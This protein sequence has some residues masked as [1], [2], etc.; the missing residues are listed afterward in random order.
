MPNLVTVHESRVGPEETKGGKNGG[1]K[2][3]FTF[4]EETTFFRFFGRNW[5]KLKF[6]LS[7]C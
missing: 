7:F 2:T 1:K 3:V 5:K 4:P 6:Q